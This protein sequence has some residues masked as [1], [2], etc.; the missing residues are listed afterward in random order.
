MD[1]KDN[2]NGL[3]LQLDKCFWKINSIF[4]C[5]NLKLVFSKVIKKIAYD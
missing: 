3:I 2:L 4:D 1:F 5:P